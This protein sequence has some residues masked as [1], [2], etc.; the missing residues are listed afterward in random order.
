MNNEFKKQRVSLM[1]GVLIAY[2][3]TCIIFIGYA[4]LLTYSNMSEDRISLVV[5]VTCVISA[6]VAGFDS[7]KGAI[8]KGWL[9]GMIAGALYAVILCAIMMWVQKAFVID[10]RGVTLIIL[11]LA[12]GGLGGIIGINVK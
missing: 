9:W 7:A 5:T 1:S 4:I 3:I 10:S 2:A 11:S 12:A 8:D 6:I